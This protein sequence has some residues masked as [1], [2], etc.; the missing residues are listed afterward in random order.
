MMGLMMGVRMHVYSMCVYGCQHCALGGKNI[1]H[2]VYML[3]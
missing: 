3:T 1:G 2:N